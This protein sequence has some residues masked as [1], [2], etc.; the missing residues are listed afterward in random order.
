MWPPV[1]GEKHGEQNSANMSGNFRLFE[2]Q[3]CLRYVAEYGLMGRGMPE[4]IDKG[5]NESSNDK[6]AAEA[7]Q[8]QPQGL[9]VISQR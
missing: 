4:D 9:S 3:A 6:L 5:W 1:R 7:A 8:G 2:G